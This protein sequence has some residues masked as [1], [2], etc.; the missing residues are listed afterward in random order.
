MKTFIVVFFALHS[1]D[2]ALFKVYGGATRAEC[3]A[4]IAD[5]V[6]RHRRVNDVPRSIG[7]KCEPV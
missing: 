6:L 1:P 3:N 7:A 4:F 2:A 5:L